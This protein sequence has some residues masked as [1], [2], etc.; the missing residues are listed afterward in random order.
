MTGI[1]RAGAIC[2]ANSRSSCASPGR[3]THAP[4]HLLDYLEAEGGPRR[5]GDAR[6][7]GVVQAHLAESALVTPILGGA[8]ERA[9]HTAAPGRRH[10]VDGGDVAIPLG[11]HERRSADVDGAENPDR[12]AA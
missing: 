4:P 10:H 12:F 8:H 5:D 1:Q 9:H 3:R 7:R 11:Q 2:E 6:R